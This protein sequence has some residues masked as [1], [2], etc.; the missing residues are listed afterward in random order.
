MPAIMTGNSLGW[1][2]QAIELGDTTIRAC[3]GLTIVGV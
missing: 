3:P 1:Q 2:C